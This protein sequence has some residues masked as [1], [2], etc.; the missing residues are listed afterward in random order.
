MST[1]HFLIEDR[2]GS[3]PRHVTLAEFLEAQERGD[4]VRLAFIENNVTSRLGLA[5]AGGPFSGRRDKPQN[6]RQ[7]SVIETQAMR[8]AL[9]NA[10]WDVPRESMGS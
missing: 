5:H 6:S 7:R 9:I 1:S 3:N 10:I 4:P 8:E 2:D